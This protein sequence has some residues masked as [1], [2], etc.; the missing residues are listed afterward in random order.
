[1]A[2]GSTLFQKHGIIGFFSRKLSPA[3]VNYTNTERKLLAIT[4]SLKY[5]GLIV[6]RANIIVRTDHA[7][8]IHSPDLQSSRAQR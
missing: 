7:N 4:E 6:Y 5:L 3:Q 1:M 8:L 2:I